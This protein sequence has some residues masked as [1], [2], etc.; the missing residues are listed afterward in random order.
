MTS[1]AKA[2]YF[3]AVERFKSLR[4]A[5]GAELMAAEAAFAKTAE[6]HAFLSA[7]IAPLE[8]TSGSAAVVAEPP[9]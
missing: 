9:P 5:S 8:N 3:A 2:A 6:G 7:A 1:P 4:G